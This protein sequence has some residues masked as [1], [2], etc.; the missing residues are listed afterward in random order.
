MILRTMVLAMLLGGCSYNPRITVRENFDQ[1]LNGMVGRD[2]RNFEN[3]DFRLGYKRDLIRSHIL[4]NGHLENYYSL[5]YEGTKCVYVLEIDP[6]TH[7]IQEVR[8]DGDPTYCII[9]I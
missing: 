3:T 6:Q 5:P 1:T 4:E 8:I 9:P 7:I 2:F